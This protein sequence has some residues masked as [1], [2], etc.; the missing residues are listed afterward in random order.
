MGLDGH[1][2]EQSKSALQCTEKATFRA[3][4][5]PQRRIGTRVVY[6][7]IQAMSYFYV[8]VEEEIRSIHLAKEHNLPSSET[9]TPANMNNS[10][11]STPK[12]A[13]QGSK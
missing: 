5:R 10:D 1:G 7:L 3:C 9:H 13:K 8:E 11:N 6:P 4:R 2:E 12:L